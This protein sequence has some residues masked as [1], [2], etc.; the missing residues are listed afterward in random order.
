MN[1]PSSKVPAT[2]FGAA[3]SVLLATGGVPTF[4]AEVAHGTVRA[5]C[6]VGIY[7]LRGGGDVD[8]GLADDGHLRWRR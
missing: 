7:A 4:A 2:L 3:I 8:I 1:D 6:H 5:D